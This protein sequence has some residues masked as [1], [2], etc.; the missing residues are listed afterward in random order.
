MTL[1]EISNLRLLNQG[2][3][4]SNTATAKDVV[5]R[6]GALQ[7]QDYNMAKWAL[8]L[9]MI[10]STD[11]ETETAL[12]HGDIIRT[13]VLRPTWHFVS[14]SDIYWMLE[15]TAG[16]I[17]SSMNSR[18]RQLELSMDV[19][20][21]SFDILAKEL[22]NGIN[23]TREQIAEKLVVAGIKTDQNR[24][25]HI[26]MEAELEQ[27][28]CSGQKA[29]NK[30][31]YGLLRER[32]P[33]R[34]TLSKD[35]SLAE[36]AKR[37]FTSHGPATQKD[38]SWWS[39]LAAGDARK[40]LEMIKSDLISE[41]IGPEKYWFSSSTSPLVA[42]TEPEFHLLPAFDEFL[43]SYKDRT[44]S[45]ELIHNR[46]AVSDNGIFRPVVVV[47]GKV[48]GIWNRIIRNDRVLIEID[49]LRPTTKNN[50]IQAEKKALEYGMF[51]N[52]KTEVS[53]RGR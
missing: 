6:M 10:Q 12:N 48:V 7:A 24:L 23:L 27:L 32:V 18:N 52:K 34:I 45:L 36:L 35:Q 14:A 42:K 26:L 29:G 51:L 11:E 16:R 22:L 37:Y 8:G 31:T 5:Q 2:V 39:G 44:S 41:T 9:R 17:K 49:F 15:L 30:L 19:F 1:T 33:V 25:S 40:A 13:H 20:I 50:L 43:I 3:T 47:N 46:K 28:I 53:V 38:F 21:K 4:D